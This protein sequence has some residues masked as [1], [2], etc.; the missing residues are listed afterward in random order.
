[1]SKVED[2]A[3]TWHCENQLYKGGYSEPVFPYRVQPY[4][5]HNYVG[6]LD[7]CH[8]FAITS[9]CATIISGYMDPI[10]KSRHRFTILPHNNYY[11]VVV[12]N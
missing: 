12:G 9:T 5:T 7:Y 8:V 6:H 11:D 1:M 10:R 2:M 3:R 4:I